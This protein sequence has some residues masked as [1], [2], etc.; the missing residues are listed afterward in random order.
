VNKCPDA[1]GDKLAEERE[2]E[3]E[4][5]ATM[6]L[7]G[8]ARGDFDDNEII[9]FIFLQPG[10]V[11]K[12]GQECT[13]GRPQ[14]CDAE[15][16]IGAHV[17][18]NWILLDNQSTV[19]VFYNNDIP[20]TITS[21]YKAVTLA[22]DIMYVNRISFLVTVSRNIKF[23]TAEMLKSETAPTLL[24]AIKQV[25][26]AYATGGFV[27]TNLVANSQFEPLRADL[28][29]VAIAMHCVSRDE[30]VPEIERY[31]QTVKER[32]RCNSNM[33]S[34]FTKLP[35]IIT[36]TMVYSST[37]WLNM[38]PPIDGISTTISPLTLIAGHKLDYNNHCRLYLRPST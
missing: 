29:D 22:L 27:I 37:F 14:E 2:S 13:L 4:S 26:K 32:T 8:A 3:G 35:H 18:K 19:D 11:T 25:K 16:T 33:R 10:I 1:S 31:I 17:P 5:G 20:A 9:E 28:A 30:H 21:R 38:F 15:S 34:P 7:A 12:A 6:L 23:G 24:E 36:I